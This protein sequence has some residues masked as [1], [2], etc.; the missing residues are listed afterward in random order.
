MMLVAGA[1]GE[2]A[3]R[4]VEQFKETGGPAGTLPSRWL[5]QPAR[6]P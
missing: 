5:A 3:T 6:A 2:P 1:S 4:R